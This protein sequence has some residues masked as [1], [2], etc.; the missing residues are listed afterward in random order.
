MIDNSK[1]KTTRTT[2]NKERK[3]EYDYYI[4]K[5]IEM[6][7]LIDRESNF[8]NLRFTSNI[9]PTVPQQILNVYFSVADCKTKL[10]RRF[11]LDQVYR[12]FGQYVHRSVFAVG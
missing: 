5:L 8:V 4:Y 12:R 1:E 11:S 3:K 9:M 6:D 10:E 2:T 7:G